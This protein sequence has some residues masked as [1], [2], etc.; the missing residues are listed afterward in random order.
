[1]DAAEEDQDVKLQ[2]AS[3]ELIADLHRS[4][5]PFLWKTT[6]DGKL[7]IRRRVRS[8]EA[9][10]L[11]AL[12]E[13]F[14]EL[15]QLLDP[16]L[17]TF[18][19][20]LSDALLAFLRAKPNPR[21]LGTQQVDKEHAHQQ[22]LMPLS[23]AICRLIYTFC[24]IR[25]EK[26][27]VRFLS[28]ETR[29][30]ELLLSALETYRGDVSSG[31]GQT[32]AQINISGVWG[33]EERYVVLLW[34]S[35]LLLAPF[36]LTSIS[37]SDD[38]Q[39]AP[40]PGLTW[41]QKLPGVTIRV[42]SLAITY[43]SSSGKEKDA[44]KV[45]LV[46]VAMRRDMQEL[47]V[48]D[49]LVKWALSC[50]RPST[51]VAESTY[52]YIGVLSFL[53]GILVSS[54]NTSDMDSYL[55]NIFY[56]MQDISTQ[57]NA[58]YESVRSSAVARKTLIK[59]Y[60][61]ISV[62]ILRKP[63]AMASSEIVESTIGQMLEF[64]A[65]QA[66]PVRLAAS[67]A[68]SIITLKLPEDMASQVVD[69]VLE[70]LNNNVLWVDHPNVERRRNLSAVNPLEWHGLILTLSHLLYRR[71]PP[72]QSLAEII[73]ALLLGLSFEQRSTSGSSLGTN[74][75]DAAC[76]GIWALARRYTTIELQAISTNEMSKKIR[77]EHQSVIQILASELVVCACLDLA[78]NIRRGASAALQELIGR[79]PDTVAEGIRVVQVVDYHAVALRSRAVQSV[80]LEAAQLSPSYMNGLVDGL[81][82]WRGVG[83]AD[84]TSR[85]N[86]ATSL[87]HLVWKSY[88]GH[89][90]PAW[91]V[92]SN[93]ITRIEGHIN[94]LKAREVD[95][96]HG[97][98]LCLSSVI[99]TLKPLFVASNLASELAKPTGMK[100]LLSD[101]LR[102]SASMLEDARNSAYRRPE[103]L[104]EAMSRLMTS[105]Y[106]ILAADM[107]FKGLP[108]SDYPVDTF[109]PT[110]A[111]LH[112][113]DRAYKLG[114]APNT[115]VLGLVKGLLASWLHR[116]EKEV[117]EAASDASA[118]LFI[119]LNATKREELVKD[120]A[121][122]VS[123]NSSSRTGQDKGYLYALWDIVPFAGS[124][125]NDICD[126]IYHRWKTSQ[127]IETHSAILSCISRR[128]P[129]ARLDTISD[130]I[131][132]GLDDYTTDSR[133]DVGSIVRIEAVKAAAQIWQPVKDMNEMKKAFF[134][135][136]FGKV[137]RLATEKLDKVRIEGQ[138][139]VASVCREN[140]ESSTFALAS[141]SSVSYF[142][143]ILD[144]ETHDWLETG[145]YKPEWR[146]EMFEGY[147]T[148]ADTGSED[149]VRVSRAALADFCRNDE[150]VNLVCQTLF[151]VVKKNLSNDRVLVP[152][153]EVMGFLF[154]IGILQQS[155]LN[156]QSFTLLVQKA[157]YK[158]GNVRKLEACIKM[159]GGLVEVY[160]EEALKRL[161]ALLMHPFPRVRSQVVDT[162]FVVRGV[163]RGV[164]WGKG[165]KEDVQKLKEALGVS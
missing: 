43:L 45:L 26:V 44:A 80:A 124:L 29:H 9:D 91:K 49:A 38:V 117:I 160:P 101:I 83:D 118:G 122:V 120:W 78:G 52:Y 102:L 42:I 77:D 7:H 73:P 154:D 33:W 30:L 108:V 64:L 141:T 145:P 65:D 121:A 97:L 69:A 82:G 158:T 32:Q 109:E 105:L 1:M 63:E 62:L 129:E 148:S 14:Q 15:P 76:F 96:R 34:L 126:A 39:K 59:V 48:L 56:I 139:A 31:D 132:A 164:N 51:E 16:H 23:K 12:L 22:L 163:G 24:K 10:R 53:A 72:P 11:I 18:V 114:S 111:T 131:I 157:H 113:V 40:I 61:S 6:T 75:R 146:A 17:N 134:N 140:P 135:K 88:Q 3:A 89:P 125:G 100:S 152:T 136:V 94:E 115:E 86:T 149:L 150:N 41:P 119:L 116:N 46:R 57:E 28:T 4:L 144:M 84:A 112:V 2:R 103:L 165:N 127:D 106:S 104:A 67:K 137:L 159:Y 95:I 147:N 47:G 123:E 71:S 155:P 138:Q 142:R 13:P 36:D 79:H 20:A 81:F 50:L 35:H 110:I 151:E 37:S 27:I 87:G 130:M 98:V 99:E 55:L 54:I 93:I 107:V 156:W 21:P 74:V 8:R 70:S 5:Q 143:F 161:T 85:R 128:V 153:L 92:F 60:R 162:L 25:G 68:L 19:P 133:G 66:T 58:V 90:E